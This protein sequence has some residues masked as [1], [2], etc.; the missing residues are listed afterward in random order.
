MLE[1]MMQNMD[2][3]QVFC[4]NSIIYE[5]NG[6]LR[7]LPFLRKTLA[8]TAGSAAYAH[9]SVVCKDAFQIKNVRLN[10]SE[11][12]LILGFTSLAVGGRRESVGQPNDQY[13]QIEMSLDQAMLFLSG[14]NKDFAFEMKQLNE[15]SDAWI[16]EEQDRVA[17]VQEQLKEAAR[18]EEEKNAARSDTKDWGA[19]S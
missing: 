14:F 8:I 9:R 17:L 1:L 7:T 11:T 19:W 16:K 6:G 13:E 12:R 18:I 10:K 2:I 3:V 5:F 4:R 15:D